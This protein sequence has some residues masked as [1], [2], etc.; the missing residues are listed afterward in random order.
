[1]G[2]LTSFVLAAVTAMNETGGT[3]NATAHQD[4]AGGGLLHVPQAKEI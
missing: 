1:M 4:L 2:I 3:S